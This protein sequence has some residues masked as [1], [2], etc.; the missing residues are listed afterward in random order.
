MELE[1]ELEWE[2]ELEF[3]PQ[4]E[5]ELEWELELKPRNPWEFRPGTPK[6]ALWAQTPLLGPGGT[7]AF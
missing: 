3:E 5:W 6:Y 4:L 1:W 7:L 2:L